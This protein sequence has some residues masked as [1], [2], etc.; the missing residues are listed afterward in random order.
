[1]RYVKA[2]AH[3]GLFYAHGR[4]LDVHGFTDADWAGSSYD[5]R[6]TSGYAFTLGSAVV[7]WSCWSGGSGSNTH[8]HKC[9]TSRDGE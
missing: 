3:Y 8:T 2:S 6:S 5:R 7:S 1:M 4:D 9:S